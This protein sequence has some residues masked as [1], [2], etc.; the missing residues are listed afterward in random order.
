MENKVMVIF[1]PVTYRFSLR[2]VKSD[3][4]L[5]YLFKYVIQCTLC[6]QHSSQQKFLSFANLI[7]CGRNN[8][9]IIGSKLIEE[10]CS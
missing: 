8:A 2:H 5:C 3:S 7:M 4:K 6:L 1:C 10:V 9:E